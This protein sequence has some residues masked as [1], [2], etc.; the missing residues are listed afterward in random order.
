MLFDNKPPLVRKHSNLEEF[1]VSTGSSIGASFSQS[2]TETPIS[3]AFRD[4]ELIRANVGEGEVKYPL[5]SSEQYP[6]EYEPQ[7][8]KLSIESATSQIKAKGLLLK[9]PEEGYTQ[10][11]LDIIIDRKEQEIMRTNKINASK[12]FV[13]TIGK[14]SAAMAAQVLD[15]V[16]VAASFIPVVAPSKYAAMLKAATGAGQRAAI[17]GGV[18]ATEGFVGSAL[19]E[20]IIYMA[21]QREQADYTMSDSLMNVGLGTVFGAGLHAGAGAVGDAIKKGRSPTQ[22]EPQGYTASRVAEANPETREA[23]LKTAVSQEAQS[24]PSNVDSVAAYDPALSRVY[25]VTT[26]SDIAKSQPVQV[27]KSNP[28]LYDF[29]PESL[30]ITESDFKDISNYKGDASKPI[31]VTKSEGGYEILDGHHRTKIAKRD[32][33][34]VKAIVIPEKDVLAMRDNKVHQGE[35][36]SE[37]I[38]TGKAAEYK[39]K[40]ERGEAEPVIKYDTPPPAQADK[41]QSLQNT[42]A[43][44]ASRGADPTYAKAATEKVNE[45]EISID[46]ELNFYMEKSKSIEQNLGIKLD[47]AVELDD[48]IKKAESDAIALE[49]AVTCRMMK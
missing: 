40:I 47:N 22:T 46:D 14:F 23:M 34:K 20:P 15:P 5:Y 44:T 41:G 30:K 36:L 43:S 24:V 6:I 18:G 29:E 1:A 7:G 10:K 12:G 13:A 17:R 11:A 37:W 35:M 38:A 28:F 39:T 45:P 49:A 8:K 9:V 16:N 21:K 33:K 26:K 32:G 3:S 25:D 31:T 4:S 48:A 42:A 2:W 27:S 19:V